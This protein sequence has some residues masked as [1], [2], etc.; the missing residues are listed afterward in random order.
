[1]IFVFSIVGSA[2][3]SPTTIYGTYNGKT[4]LFSFSDLVSAYG[5]DVAAFKDVW[6][7]TVKTSM[8]VDGKNVSWSDFIAAVGNGT[9]TTADGYAALP[10]AVTA[11]VP[12]TVTP[13][14]ASGSVGAEAANPN[15]PVTTVA[16]S[17]IAATNGAITPTFAAAAPAGLALADFTVTATLGG[18][19][20]TLQSL[21]FANNAFT[22]TAVDKA[23][24]A[25][26]L[27]ITVAAAASSAKVTGTASFT[28]NIPANDAPAAPA[29]TADD[30]NNV[31]VGIDTT[32][33]YSLDNGTTW[34]A[35]TTAPDLSGDK[36]VK[37][38]VKATDTTPA[39]AV[40]TM[41]F[42]KNL[43]AVSSVNAINATTV[44][45]TLAAAKA[46]AIATDF[47]VTVADVAVV[48]T[49]VTANTNNIKYTLTVNLTGK[50][51]TLK[52]NGTA[53][54]AAIDFKAPTLDNVVATKATTV[55]LTLSEAL[56][57]ASVTNL[58]NY[59]IT[60][61]IAVTQAA[62][63]TGDNKVVVLT[64]GGETFGLTTYTIAVS[65]I[66][67]AA[68]NEMTATTKTF[69]GNDTPVIKINN[70]VI[71]KSDAGLN[72]DA[73]DGGDDVIYLATGETKATTT[74]NKDILFELN[75]D[76]V[77]SSLTVSTV[78]LYN[79]T[80][81]N[82]VPINAP[83]RIGSKIIQIV[84]AASLSNGSN[85]RIE[86]SGV[87]VINSY[88]TQVTAPDM[89]VTFIVGTAATLTPCNNTTI[90]VTAKDAA[91][92]TLL[93]ATSDLKLD[94]STVTT[95]TVK[96][97]QITTPEA[98]KTY[99]YDAVTDKRVED[100]LGQAVATTLV[101][102]T[103]S[104]D[105]SRKRINFVPSANL[106][107]AGQFVFVI[108]GVKNT[109]G[110]SCAAVQDSFATA[111]TVAPSVQN[112]ISKN[113]VTNNMVNVLTSS[114]DIANDP[115]LTPQLDFYVNFDKS[116]ANPTDAA[117]LATVDLY[118]IT[119]ATYLNAPSL[120]STDRTAID[121]VDPAASTVTN[122][123]LTIQLAAPLEHGHQ[124]KMTVTGLVAG[125]E[126]A[127]PVGKVE[128][129]F[130]TDFARPTITGFYQDTTDDNA[131]GTVATWTK[132]T[133]NVTNIRKDGDADSKIIILLSK[134]IDPATI[135]AVKVYDVTGNNAD[136]TASMT[137]A[138]DLGNTAIT[139]DDGDADLKADNTYRIE[140]GTTIK[141]APGTGSTLA[142][143]Q[144]FTFTTNDVNFT[145]NTANSRIYD[146]AQPINGEDLSAR[147]TGVKISKSIKLEFSDKVL[148]SSVT[149]SDIVLKETVAGTAVSSTLTIDPADSKIV[150]VAPA[151]NLKSLTSYTLS[152]GT[153]LKDDAGN[154]FQTAWDYE[155]MTEV[156]GNPQVISSTPTNNATDVSVTPTIVL[157]FDRAMDTIS[158][159]SVIGLSDTKDNADTSQNIWLVA[160]GGAVYDLASNA[161]ALYNAATKQVTITLNVNAGQSLSYNTKYTLSVDTD[162]QDANGLPLASK[163]NLIFTTVA[164][165]TAPSIKEVK[166]NTTNKVLSTSSLVTS[167]AKDQNIVVI[168]NDKDLTG[169]ATVTIFNET[170]QN[171]AD[172]FGIGNGIGVTDGVANEDSVTLILA[173][174]N[175]F[176]DKIYRMTISGVKDLRNNVMTAAVYRFITGPAPI[177]TVD[178]DG[179]NND[180]AT[181]YAD[182]A[183]TANSVLVT[184]KVRVEPNE[185][186]DTTT[187][188]ADSSYIQDPSDNKMAATI[189][190]DGAFHNFTIT[191]NANLAKGTTYHV[192]L[193]NGIK[194][195]TGNNATAVDFTFST[196]LDASL[197]NFIDCRDSLL[198]AIEQNSVVQEVYT[199]NLYLSFDKNLKPST[200]NSTNVKLHDDTDNKYVTLLDGNFTVVDG[201]RIRVTPLTILT[202]GHV[203]TITVSGVT[204]NGTPAE[205]LASTV[206]RTFAVR[207]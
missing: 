78:K 61:S 146:T 26:D 99:S 186:I 109:V 57:S 67:D 66:K 37:V 207:K 40:T 192:Y 143:K 169:N 190:F 114:T 144:S 150:L 200:V 183:D 81:S 125:N 113:S 18:A 157:T 19:A 119:T 149:S 112:V 115:N 118:D 9:A 73:I 170:D 178:T 117:T 91:G 58:T 46:G 92:A 141:A 132:L 189:T 27:V 101:A 25:K 3:A 10:A 88:G 68:G 197:I 193:T 22:F 16:I 43:L 177:L 74:V 154:P 137:I 11:P 79:A 145:V 180:S 38:R 65:G 52:V 50:E 164:D 171:Y 94:A 152:V 59:A 108:E 198:S 153:G 24:K 54:A 120:A 51:G 28:V 83:V 96:L 199:D 103:V 34:T 71:D 63:K 159:N 7:N 135:T 107:S 187:V 97:Y 90:P 126:N 8:T 202:V 4:A 185:E 100:N 2:A 188:T 48:V 131:I 172:G 166:Q 93:F 205:T 138:A 151:S 23:A 42:T 95:D 175:L 174:N 49:A 156:T 127:T 140:V 130:T 168:F 21:V 47:N 176:A 148:A 1:M 44:E 13:V 181:T 206:S 87:K 136:V 64:L 70:V 75:Q 147:R 116:I 105:D 82:Y 165:I 98:N 32:M 30:T 158:A 20:Y 62:I 36:T 39:S 86:L 72:A 45:A 56:A 203:Y 29:V 163:Y 84:P 122:G 173:A 6:T 55:E 179:P 76:I 134:A 15:A 14:A 160:E 17:S 194:D 69:P 184:G 80:A 133:D 196:V 41:T 35:Y 106:A 142:A 161:T 12:A 129:T 155:F 104:Y 33:E 5:N 85:Y 139:I 121:G 123:R 110:I 182:A 53:A 124:Y 89:A 162:V 167:V 77:V 195:I 31:I 204:G 201:N 60:P 111:D 102:G 191:P 128:F